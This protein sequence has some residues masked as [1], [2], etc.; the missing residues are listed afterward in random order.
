MQELGFCRAGPLP[1]GQICATARCRAL[2]PVLRSA[3]RAARCCVGTGSLAQ[4]VV[5]WEE[6][7]L[8]I[9]ICSAG[10][11]IEWRTVSARL[12]LEHQS[13]R[14]RGPTAARNL[15]DRTRTRDKGWVMGAGAS[16][17]AAAVA[18]D[19]QGAEDA[20]FIGYGVSKLHMLRHLIR[21]H[22][23]VATIGLKP[24]RVSVDV[25][26]A[27]LLSPRN[28]TLCNQRGIKLNRLSEIFRKI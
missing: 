2:S 19:D 26:K 9:G 24:G 17:S 16:R 21:P 23:E 18:R 3:R 5:A 1:L 15:S 8:S 27:I 13:G 20:H 6:V 10:L 25:C 22:E 14:G 11:N 28:T 7:V 4:M 12:R